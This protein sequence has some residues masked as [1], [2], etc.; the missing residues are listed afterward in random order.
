MHPNF[1]SLLSLISQ[2][3]SYTTLLGLL[4]YVFF[5]YNKFRK[6]LHAEH[7]EIIK[8]NQTILLK[9]TDLLS[10]MKILISQKLNK[11]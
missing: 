10:E 11:N 2:F 9:L 3:S 8:E 1:E 7:I 6:E 4:V 5:D